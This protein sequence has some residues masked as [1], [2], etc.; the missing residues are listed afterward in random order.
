MRTKAGLFDLSHMGRV[1]V[2]GKDAEAYLQK[3]QT[4]DAA[5]LQKGQIR[6]SLLL[7]EQGLTRD[8]IL[9]YRDQID[10]GSY[11]LVINAGNTAR[12]LAILAGQ[13]DYDLKVEDQT[14]NSGCSRFKGLSRKRSRRP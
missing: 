4:N 9:V 10:D 2:T 8:D 12:D 14:K 1:R 3:V 7:D 6:Y 5:T 11:F 13:Q